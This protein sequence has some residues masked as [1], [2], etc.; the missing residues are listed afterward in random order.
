MHDT[1][2]PQ[3]RRSIRFLST[4]MLAL[5]GILIPVAVSLLWLAFVVLDSDEF[6]RTVTPII[7]MPSVQSHLAVSL[8]SGVERSITGASNA[9]PAIRS[10]ITAAGGTNVVI[11]EIEHFIEQALA[12]PEFRLVWTDINRLAHVEVKRIL[13]GQNLVPGVND[14]T[15]TLTFTDIQAALQIDPNSPLG[16]M[17]DA[18][19]ADYAPSIEVMQ[20]PVDIPAADF[21][22]SNASLLA[23][24]VSLLCALLFGIGLWLSRDRRRALIFAGALG[25][26][27]LLVALLVRTVMNDSLGDVNGIEGELARE[28]AGSLTSPLESGLWLIA[29]IGGIV[30]LIAWIWPKFGQA[31]PSA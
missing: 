6:A 2:A 26:I 8:N 12:S 29:A 11:P 30:A 9:S 25:L 5:A 24:S 14:E 3:A 7:D 4:V 18:L 27:S 15:L 21:L 1:A 16:V 22:I 23:V 19:P 28:Y 17:L 31:E 10:L 13:R 20:Q